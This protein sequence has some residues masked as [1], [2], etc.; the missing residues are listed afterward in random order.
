[1]IVIRLQ[2]TAALREASRVRF[3]QNAILHLRDQMAER[4]AGLNDSHLGAL[5]D[6]AIGRAVALGFQTELEVICFLDADV[7]A[8]H[9]FYEADENPW[10]RRALA[11]ASLTPTDRARLL[12]SLAIAYT[13]CSFHSAL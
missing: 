4:V 7:L 2:Q 8:G 12:L 13:D 9:R 10:A 5:V 6:D 11:D 3:V 1:M